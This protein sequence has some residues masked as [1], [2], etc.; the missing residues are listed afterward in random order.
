[1]SVCLHHGPNQQKNFEQLSEF[2]NKEDDSSYRVLVPN[3]LSLNQHKASI[4]NNHFNPTLIGQN[5]M[6][7]EDFL[8]QLVKKSTHRAHLANHDLCH[9]L[10]FSLCKTKHTSLLNDKDNTYQKVEELLLFFQQVKKCGL[11]IKQANKTFGPHI[12]NQTVF[13]LF[14]DYQT[15]LKN[16]FYY[17][18]GDLH[19]TTLQLIKNS[20]LIIGSVKTLYLSQLY[21]LH[22]GQREIIRQLKHFNPKLNLHIFYPEDFNQ[23]NQK[24]TTAYEDLGDISDQSQYNAPSQNSQYSFIQHKSPFHEIDSIT[25]NIKKDLESNYQHNQLGIILTNNNYIKLLCH[26]LDNLNIPYSLQ[27]NLP[28]KDYLSDSELN[29]EQINKK[30]NKNAISLI[31]EKTTFF[32]TQKIKA[33]AC[34]QEM[35]N[36]LNFI[37]NLFCEITDKLD[38]QIKN[39]YTQEALHFHKIPAN[40]LSHALVITNMANAS[41]HTKRKLYVAGLNLENLTIQ[42][43]SSIYSPYLYSKKEFFELLESPSYHLSLT[44]KKINNLL[45]QNLDLH[46]TFPESDL[47]GKPTTKLNLENTN[48]IKSTPKSPND[49]SYLKERKTDYF[50]TKKM[51]F[52]ISALQEYINCPF[53]YYAAHQ[54][55][56]GR[57]DKDDLEPGADIKG[58]FVHKVLFRMIKENEADYIEGLEY[59]SY[60]DKVTKALASIIQEEIENE[61]SFKDFNQKLI[62]FYAWRCYK[63]INEL[64]N[65]ESQYFLNKIKLTTPKYY[66]WSFSRNNTSLFELQTDNGAVTIRGQI[67]RIDINRSH[68][69]FSI[70]DYKTGKLPSFNSIKAG[71][72]IQLPL[73]MMAT[74]SILLNEFNPSGAFYYG[75]KENDIKGFSISETTD[76][77][78]VN[79]RSQIKLEAWDE[80]QSNVTHA[81]NTAVKGIHQ[82][83]FS[84]KPLEKNMCQYCDYNKICEYQAKPKPANLQG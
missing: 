59:K 71:S 51:S 14:N 61:D 8:L 3:K 74:K 28:A 46:L 32:P 66:E 76:T 43:D 24:L 70:I 29:T 83:D 52:S 63:T 62:E 81:I 49:T 54:L 30:F 1:M 82:G 39:N 22:P 16:R 26:N 79:K 55:L 57:I 36:H 47:S 72:S 60:R 10:L 4:L 69:M 78:M 84:P 64:I 27:I 48:I 34:K 42:K 13:D 68:K 19:L 18:S 15:E 50:K 33:I 38:Q 31:S 56:L 65:N 37:D 12:S 77:N 40:P 7:W 41:F 80:I 45:Q 9:Y 11:D 5:I 21:P 6:T 2:I 17:D 25:Q 75:L 20:T 58:S 23:D 53:K 73:Y 35:T 44:L 67:D